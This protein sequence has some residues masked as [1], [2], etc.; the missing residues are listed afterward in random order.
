M[1]DKR[2]IGLILM[3]LCPFFILG[4]NV[5]IIGKTNIP[6]ALVRLLTY[7]EMLTCHQTKVAETQSDKDGKFTLKTTINEITPAQIAINLERVE[8]IL[9]PGGKYN[10][11][12][13]IPEQKDDESYFEK[14]QPLLKINTADD[15][16]LYSQYV[17]AENLIDDFIY[18]NFQ[19]IYRGRKIYLMDTIENQIYRQLG[20]VKYDYVK[21]MI[22]YRK[23]AVVMA[24]NTE[25]VIT[26]YIDNQKVLYSNKAYMDVFAELFG[27]YFN[28]RD[29][30]QANLENAFYSGYDNFMTYL[31][32]NDFLSRNRQIFELVTMIEMRRLY[33]ENS[34]DKTR[35]LSYYKK[36]GETSK[37][38]KNKVVANDFIKHLTK[39]SY[40]SDAPTFALKDKNG[41][42]VQLSD[43]QGNMVL[44]QFVGRLS[45]LITNEFLTLNELHKQWG[46]S[47]IIVTVV[48][49][50]SFDNCAQMF[51][52]QGF[53]WTILNLDDDI[54]LLEDYDVQ[55]FPAYF[56][57][58]RKNKIGMA[59][60]PS[61]DQYLDYHVR[62]ISKY[63]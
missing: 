21:D 27:G 42:T 44:L 62:R 23:A 12:I 11:E 13:V 2:S 1:K 37:Y 4:Q 6:N 28:K 49:K 38:Q 45:S 26:E 30:N 20:K 9:N 19:Q 43:F 18:D 17:L 22:K 59:P 56:I 51:D 41:K 8:I 57:L 39:L 61:P 14:E 47:V 32:K 58:K 48:T 10:V 35:I 25:K 34:Y 24:L 16:G 31:G 60:A 40:D 7:D 36:I 33:Y 15:G 50:E 54:L 53:N 55:S 5:T 52:K 3:F 46:D 29:Y 63:L